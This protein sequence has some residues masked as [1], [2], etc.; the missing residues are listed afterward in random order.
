MKALDRT[1]AVRAAVLRKAWARSPKKVSVII[2]AYNSDQEGLRR[3]MRSLAAQTMPGRHIEVIVVDDGSTDDTRQ[4]LDAFARR[5]ANLSVRTIPNSGWAS[6]PRNVGIE[7]A[8]GEYV[9]FMDHDDE[10]FP[11]GL[12]DAYEYGRQHRADVVNAKEIRT[13][14]WSWGWDSFLADVPCAAPDD[15]QA[16]IPMTPHKLYRREFLRNAGIRFPEGQRILWEDIY[17]NTEMLAHDARVATWSR[18]PFY[19]WVSTG[20]N[21]STTFGRDPKEFWWNLRHLFDFFETELAGKPARWPLVAHQLR[22][23]VLKSV[24]PIALNRS[25]QHFET[26]YEAVRDIVAD[27]A[28]PDRDADFRSV[29]RCRLELV[30]RGDA[31][32]QRLLADH[33]RDVTAFPS[34]DEVHWDAGELVVTASA[35]LLRRDGEPMRF[36]KDGGRWLRELPPE[37]DDALSEEARDVAPDLAHAAFRISVK[38]RKSRSTWA[39]GENGTVELVDDGTGSA[40]ARASVTARFD[41]VAFAAEHSVQ[42][43]VWELAAR[44]DVFGYGAHRGLRGGRACV[45][46]LGPVIAVGYVNKSGLYSLDVLGEVRTPTGS[47]PPV[48]DDVLVRTAPGGNSG[49]VGVEVDMPLRD[50]HVH[51]TGTVEGRV[52]IGRQSVKAT[53]DSSSGTATIRF[54]ADVASGEHELQ[55]RFLGRTGKTKLALSVADSTARVVSVGTSSD[56]GA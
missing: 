53:L 28:E 29:D 42:D 24:G 21:T 38:G 13:K 27:Y 26:M 40:V 5:H 56:S 37:L 52:L 47:A 34:I 35:T 41:P 4:R 44:L 2:A 18:T 17:F 31:A 12:Q 46:M 39:L 48:P 54:A 43:P 55:A 23:R 6:R 1:L 20:S 10:L 49:R 15:V 8:R 14:G 30:R 50:V 51:G 25:A 33:D 7:M 45:A 3:V 32:L 11:N 36:R 19:H 9:L 16:L 22:A